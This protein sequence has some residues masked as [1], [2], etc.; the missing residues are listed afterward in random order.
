MRHLVERVQREGAV[1]GA[2]PLYVRN[3]MVGIL[4]ARV[5]NGILAAIAT[6]ASAA[7]R[8]RA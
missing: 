3:T 7:L 5:E 2:V 1:D 8:N 4:G 6:L